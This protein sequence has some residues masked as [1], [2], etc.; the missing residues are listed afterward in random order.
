MI[1]SN[2]EFQERFKYLLQVAVDSDGFCD[3]YHENATF[4]DID[5]LY[6]GNV[7]GVSG[8]FPP[9][10]AIQ[11]LK[12]TFVVLNIS[13]TRD[14]A[15]SFKECLEYAES[16]LNNYSLMPWGYRKPVISLPF[17]CPNRREKL[18]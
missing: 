9:V 15:L 8:Y 17:V 2:K 5:R 6:M 7:V 10:R 4:R 3:R 16:K 18:T 12:Q 13:I 14:I 1:T 11:N